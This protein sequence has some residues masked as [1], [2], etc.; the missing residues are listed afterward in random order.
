[1]K[2]EKVKLHS[3]DFWSRLVSIIE[4]GLDGL[5]GLNCLGLN[6]VGLDFIGLDQH[7]EC[8]ATEVHTVPIL[9]R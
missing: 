3:A 7:N 1:M 2:H 9:T 6:F 5:D 4:I 8:G